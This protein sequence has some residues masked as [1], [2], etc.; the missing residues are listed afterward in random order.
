MYQLP[1]T[2]TQ[3]EVLQKHIDDMPQTTEGLYSRLPDD[4]NIYG[5]KSIPAVDRAVRSATM[6]R[7]FFITGNGF[8]GLGPHSVEVGDEVRILI[9]GSVPFILRRDRQNTFMKFLLIGDCYVQGIMD[10][11][12]ME[13]RRKEEIIDIV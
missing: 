2:Q 9:G 11:E 10:G 13:M 6:W 3:T 5:E 7:V 8:L 1:P 4:W 12:V